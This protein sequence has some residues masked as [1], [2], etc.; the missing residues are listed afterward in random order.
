MMELL[1]TGHG[2]FGCLGPGSC[3]YPFCSSFSCG[4]ASFSGADCPRR[5]ADFIAG[6]RLLCV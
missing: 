1:V 2:Q 5:W 6:R 4:S 3:M